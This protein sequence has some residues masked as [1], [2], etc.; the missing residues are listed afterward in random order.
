MTKILT[1]IIL[2][3]TGVRM[4][5]AKSPVTKFTS[6]DKGTVSNLLT[7]SP[8]GTARKLRKA[9]RGKGLTGLAGLR[10]AA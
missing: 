8:K 2:T 9:L 1:T 7:D 5:G 6:L 10:R 3:A 4:N